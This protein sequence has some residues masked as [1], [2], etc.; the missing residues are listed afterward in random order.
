MNLLSANQ[1]KHVKYHD[2]QTYEQSITWN[3]E[4]IM[5]KMA[6]AESKN[7]RIFLG[8]GRVERHFI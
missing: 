8:E 3:M 1:G 2:I 6:Y 7:R 4:V 5:K